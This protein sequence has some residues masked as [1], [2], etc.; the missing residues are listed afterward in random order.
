MFSPHLLPLTALLVLFASCC[1]AHQGVQKVH[2]HHGNVRRTTLVITQGTLWK[3]GNPRPDS[4]LINGTSPG[5][6]LEFDVGDTVI[7]R[8]INKLPV[9]NTT[10]HFHGLSQTQTPAS[11]GTPMVSQWPIKTG[12][13]FDYQMR[14]LKRDVSWR[15]YHAHV[16]LQSMTGFG[17]LV[18]RDTLPCA[19]ATTRDQI[20]IV[21]DY[22]YKSDTNISTGL[23]ADPFVWPGSANSIALNDASWPAPGSCNATIAQSAGVDCKD[24]TYKGPM[25]IDVDYAQPYRLR[26]LGAQTLMHLAIGIFNHSQEL[27]AVDGSHIKPIIVDYIEVMSGQRYDTL[28]HTKTREDVQSD[29]T[30]GC[31]L[32][33][34]ESRYRNPATNGWAVLRYPDSTCHIDAT[35]AYPHNNTLNYLPKAQFGWISDQFAPH[36]DAEEVAPTDEEVTRR[37][38]LNTQQIP[39]FPTKKGSRWTVDKEFFNE[40]YPLDGTEEPIPAPYL[41]QLFK[42]ERIAPSYHR[43]MHPP[44]GAQVGLD[45]LSRVFV[46]REGE[47]IDIVLVNNAS[48]VGKNTEAHPWHFHGQDHY[49]VAMGEGDFT[50]QG[51]R[52][53]RRRFSS[54]IA[55]DTTGVWPGTGDSSVVPAIRLPVKSS[56][57]WS[58]LRYKVPRNRDGNGMWLLHCHFAFHLV[59][60][61]ATVWSFGPSDLEYQPSSLYSDPDYLNFGRNVTAKLL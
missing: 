6:L 44:P 12:N 50:E 40:T 14:P 53:A 31:Y 34:L 13:Y 38:F 60:G 46:G 22:F 8:V 37:V 48:V 41:I 7:V 9:D 24:S 11:D 61:M 20:M 36:E 25:V 16:G 32:I 49:T 58:V 10:M 47:V 23:L 45:P 28:L 2:H 27:V 19:P 29:R 55:R 39:V 15:Y 43:A 42:K 59:M 30:G 56:G 18:I 26:W 54:P 52:E 17:P 5:P 4:I 35:S 1:H 51:F 33:R 3:D 21:S 57:A